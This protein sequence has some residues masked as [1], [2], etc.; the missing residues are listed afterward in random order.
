MKESKRA[1]KKHAPY[2][3]TWCVHLPALSLHQ[4]SLQTIFLKR[5]LRA[6]YPT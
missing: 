4:G 6:Q 3:K 5:K 1:K 2:V